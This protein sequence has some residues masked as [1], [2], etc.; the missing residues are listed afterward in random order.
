MSGEAGG[1][2]I[3][4]AIALALAPVVI[5]GAA[6]LGLAYGAIR[7][8]GYLGKHALDYAAEKKRE[9]ELVVGQCSVQLDSLFSQMRSVVREETDAHTRYAEQISKQFRT[10]G[11]EM[12]AVYD[13]K[14]SVEVLDRKIAN[15]RNIIN[16]KLSEEG[17]VVRRTIIDKG[18]KQISQC[19]EVIEKSNA[20]KA[21]IIKWADKSVAAVSMQKNVATEM[22]RDADAAYRVLDNMAKS[23]N[24]HVFRNQ[25]H[26]IQTTLQRAKAMM[27]QEMFQSAFSN[28]RTVIRES[29]ILAGEHVQN[30]LEMDM[31]VM[32]LKAKVE[33][34]AEELKAQRYLE[35][36]DETKR[37]KKKIKV[38]LYN[39]SQGK[40]KKMLDTLQE[41]SA[42]LDREGSST[43][44]Y[45]VEK[46]MKHFED[47][48]EPEARH[49]VDY[50]YKI[51]KGYYDRL[52]A[53]EIVA[54]FMT[55]QD[56]QMDWA[57]PVGGDVSQKLVVHF[58]QKMTGNTISVTLDNDIESGDI[59]KM[60]M[61]ILTF[62]GNGRPVTEN[63][64]KELRDNLNAALNKAGFSGA[65]GCQGHVNQSSDQV[66]MNKKETVKNM[67]TTQIV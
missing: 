5:T 53:L 52:Y 66:E 27:D 20:E 60:A 61:E 33:G 19:I 48:V 39:F 11:T 14:P 26:N 56:Y 9:K 62:Y 46:M 18:Q 54:D 35:F 42:K 23:S 8:G 15:S 47:E 17:K 12:K 45:E 16:Q 44:V 22:L 24:D 55:E 3:G 67:P 37:N 41:L 6:A 36:C 29:A 65:L 10:I 38:D 43:S 50:S 25:V 32:E 49:I 51:M 58:V 1:V 31:L 59:A 4:G 28:A 34:L 64:K 57:M 63:E 2:L 30:E 7:V 13:Q 40:Y 21:E